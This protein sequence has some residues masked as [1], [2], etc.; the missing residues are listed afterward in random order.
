MKF[1]IC[2]IA[3][4]SGSGRS[5]CQTATLRGTV[6]DESGA[7]V[8]GATITVTDIAVDYSGKNWLPSGNTISKNLPWLKSKN[9][10]GILPKPLSFSLELLLIHE[11]L[12]RDW[13][14]SG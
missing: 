6:S 4:L 7:I 9:G 5:G 2:L 13:V 8:Q 1:L 10:P 12:P 11:S 14:V 3:L